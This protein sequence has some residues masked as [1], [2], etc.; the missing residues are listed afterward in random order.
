MTV[1][2]LEPR[3][4][5]V[6]TLEGTLPWKP[7]QRRRAGRWGVGGYHPVTSIRA[8]IRCT[9]LLPASERQRAARSPSSGPH[10]KISPQNTKQP[11]TVRLPVPPT[12]DSVEHR[13]RESAQE[14]ALTSMVNTGS[15]KRTSALL[16]GGWVESEDQQ[17]KAPKGPMGLEGRL[18]LGPNIPD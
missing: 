14:T 6:R 11:K 13:T 3:D 10:G 18:L 4:F 5:T 12:V 15:N 16:Q 1:S 9:P 8:Q 2:K 17:Q 7:A